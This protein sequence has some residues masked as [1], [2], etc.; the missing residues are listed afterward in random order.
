MCN[1]IKI[2]KQHRGVVFYSYY[3][4]A[5]YCI[6]KNINKTEAFVT[7][8]TISHPTKNEQYLFALFLNIKDFI[9]MFWKIPSE[10]RTF[11]NV[12]SEPKRSLYIDID[13]YSKQTNS[14]LN[15]N[16]IGLAVLYIIHTYF[17]SPTVKKICKD[18]KQNYIETMQSFV[19]WNSSRLKTQNKCKLSFH[20][21]NMFICYMEPKHIIQELQNI[22]QYCIDNKHNLLN[23]KLYIDTAIEIFIG[24]H[25]DVSVYN[26]DN[27]QQYRM[28]Y[29]IKLNEIYSTKLLVY[30]NQMNILDQIKVNQCSCSSIPL[31]NKNRANKTTKNGIKKF[32]KKFETHTNTNNTYFR[33][34]NNISFVNNIACDCNSSFKNGGWYEFE[35]LRNNIQWQELRCIQ[36]NTIKQF[37]STLHKWH[38]NPRIYSNLPISTHQIKQIDEAVH[39]FNITTTDD[40]PLLF[41]YYEYIDEYDTEIKLEFS[42]YTKVPC[43]HGYGTHKPCFLIKYQT[44]D[45]IELNG[46]FSYYCNMCNVSWHNIKNYNN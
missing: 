16:D 29:C 39:K 4:I 11:L 18:F 19:L 17:K 7:G 36:C 6:N 21:A 15:S 26:C 12:F 5:Q 30:P 38:R 35:S 44:Q 43:K 13:Y 34:L 27:Y 45:K 40:Y 28:P 3:E 8:L 25:F 23:S 31:N 24:N 46:T 9:Q 32:T 42:T 33:K 22:S 37:T 41:K 2:I 1:V 10:K 20:I 14:L